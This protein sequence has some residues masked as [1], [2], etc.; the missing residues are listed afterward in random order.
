MKLHRSIACLLLFLMA[1][2]GGEPGEPTGTPMTPTAVSSPTGTATSLPAA[3]ETPTHTKTAVPI[4]AGTSM[5]AGRDHTCVVLGN[6][7]VNC[8]GNNEHGQLGDG[9]RKD[10][11][12]PV[13]VKN[14]GDV[15]AV[16]VGWA[17]TCALTNTG[18]VKC[19]GYNQN[20]ELGNGRTEDSAEPVEVSGLAA[21]A[22]EIDAGDDH[23]CVVTKD[24]GLYCWGYNRY[25][26]L[27]DGTRVS[28]S[29]PTRANGLSGGVKAVAA[30]WGHTCALTNADGVKCWGN[31]EEGQIGNGQE[32]EYRLSASNVSGLTGGVAGISSDGGST[33]ALKE[34]GGVECWGNNKYGQLGDGTDEIRT[35]P[36]QVSGLDAGA[37]RIAV[38]WNHA[39]AVAVTGEMLCWGW[40]YYGQLGDG[41]KTSRLQPARVAGLTDDVES[42]GVGWAH[43]CVVT[44]RSGVRCW[45]RN[46]NGQL[47]DGTLVDSPA[48]V[49]VS[50]WIVSTPTPTPTSTLTPTYTLTPTSAAT[51]TPTVTATEV[52]PTQPPVSALQA[53]DGAIATK[54]SSTCALTTTG[55]V[56]CWGYNAFGQLG[57]GT[58]VDRLTPVDVI[59]IPSDVSAVAMGYAHA[60]V[61][62]ETGGV[63][64]WGENY[65][66]QLGDGTIVDHL[67][68]MSVS[69]LESGIIGVKAGK[70]HN[71]ALTETGGVKCWGTNHRGMCGD[72]TTTDRRTAV[73]VVGLSSGVVALA[74]GRQHSC[75]LMDD[76]EIKCWGDNRSGQLGD[77]TMTDRYTPVKVVD[78]SG[79]YV[80]V[81]A[82]DRHTCALTVEGG[83]ECWGSNEFGQLGND[84]LYGNFQPKSV[85]GLSSGVSGLALGVGHTCALTATGEVKCWGWNNAGQVGNGR[86]VLSMDIGEKWPRDVIGLSGAA[87]SLAAGWG[88]TCAVMQDGG[89]MCWGSNQYGEMGDGTNTERLQPVHVRGFIG[90]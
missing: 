50:G 46:E 80:A 77:G 8:W 14:L 56:K 49:T 67:T 73:D 16:A 2:C 20:G 18:G 84:K 66:G 55:G 71:C 38:G 36:V 1:G 12:R 9:T 76:G 22:A 68:P 83:M 6:G 32:A 37:A 88:H 82:G 65:D 17:H 44:G 3:T 23:T 62:T 25:G 64:C 41:T 89:I 52:T 31:G 34:D 57:D 4:V 51:P 10:S 59:G 11:S 24:G 45:G 27:G 19:W 72:G 13:E 28:R 5:A 87:V 81:A 85:D 53:A 86:K 29:L 75:A 61:L 79:K 15:K 43:T 42:I 54:V 39:C 69:G 47:G 30:G 21:G 90:G 7:S 60:C 48:P 35:S 70:W 63:L 78:S 74:L 58:R 40:N 33:C 26:Q